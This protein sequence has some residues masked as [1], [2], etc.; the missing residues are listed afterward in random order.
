M[1]CDAKGLLARSDAIRS[2][3][4]LGAEI[5]HEVLKRHKLV[6]VVGAGEDA[7]AAE[8]D[9]VCEANELDV[10]VVVGAHWPFLN[11]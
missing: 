1:E 8:E 6:V 11:R 2:S 4:N 3:G 7:V 9:E 5:A 10:V